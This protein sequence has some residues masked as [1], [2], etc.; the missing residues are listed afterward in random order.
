MTN[1][2]NLDI[3]LL[4]INQISFT[5]TDSVIYDMGYFKNLEG[6]NSLYFILNDVDAYFEEH[7]E[8]K[9]FVFALTDKNREALENYKELWSEVKDE[10]ETIK[11][12]GPIKYEKDFMKIRFESDDNLPLGRILNIPVCIVF[13]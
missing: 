10:I 7:N 1:I 6:V 3:N 13:I 5:S 2:K 9:Y 4:G 8:N 12:I 11:G